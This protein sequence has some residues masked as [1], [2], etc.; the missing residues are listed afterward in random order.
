MTAPLAVLIIEDSESDTQMIVRLLKRAGYNVSFEQVENAAQMLAALQKQAW[1]IVISDYQLPQFDGLT[2]LELLKGTNLDIPFIVVS[3]LIGEESAVA[4]MKAGAHDYLAKNDLTRLAPAVARELE[5]AQGRL[6]RK[7][8]EQALHFTEQKYRNLVE[9]IPLMI[10]LD[11]ADESGSNLYISP[12]VK[13]LLGYMPEEFLENPTFWHQVIFPDDYEI[14]IGSISES[15][16]KGRAMVE[17]RM[18]TQDG[19][20]IW[21]RDTS[22]L[23]QGEEG[24]QSFI[25]GFIEDI[26]ERKQAVDALRESE[27]FTQAILKNSPIGISVRSSTGQ[28][29]SANDA[30]K[31]IWAIP[32]TDLQKDITRPRDTLN[33]NNR[34]D[35]LKLRHEDVRRVYEQGGNLY[36]PE[37]KIS[38]GRPGAAKW[39]SQHFYAIQDAQGRVSRVVI[40]T[41]DI[42]ERK[43]AHEIMRESEERL[44][45]VMEGSQLGY[46]DWN[47]QTDEV[48]RNERWA[49]MLGYTLHEIETTFNQWEELIHPDDRAHALQAV[50]DHLEGKTQIHRDEYRLRA[51]DGSYRWILD[52]GRIIEYDPQGRPLRMTATHTD[53][54]ERKQA[55]AQLR[56]LSRA[57]EQSPASIIITDVNGKI[58]YVN[59]KF[60]TL[61][62]YTLD[63]VQG[64][65]PRLLKSEKSPPEIYAELWQTILAGKEWRGEFLNRKKNG[66]LYWEYASISAITDTNGKINHFVSVNEDITIRKKTEESL[67]LLNIELEQQALTDYLTNLYNRRYFMTRGEEEFKRTKRNGQPLALLVLDID[68]FKRVNDSYGHE[69]GDRALQE[70]AKALK[71]NLREIDVLGRMGGEEFAVLLPNTSLN[72]AALLAERVRQTMENTS[73]EIPGNA[74]KIT[75]CVGV[76]A[77]VEGMSNIDDMFRNADSAMYQAKN[78]G[79]NRTVKYAETQ[80]E[81]IN[82][83]SNLDGE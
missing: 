62:G 30:W 66:E 73:F 4:M 70:V 79:R 29:L 37:L 82:L 20:I 2:A 8:A 63:E 74:L 15:L 42:T 53:I 71:S 57:V 25:Q 12:H 17:Y 43:L 36:L 9:Q 13:G 3:G 26:T 72:D 46:S 14:A 55:E 80:S 52:Q 39:V 65:T 64:K 24:K 41:E 5:Q 54:T 19:R 45:A 81:I 16:S 47:I 31:Q 48:R 76:S 58:E 61:T 67:R 44:T 22:I 78:A 51:K 60:T 21:V 7:Q 40:L 68:N 32:E 35:Y 28:L 1:D 10:Y 69:A 38:H 77:F 59:P 50:Q 23:I 18:I 11:N 27:S 75:I 34:D 6:E 49:G 83:L 56:Q 33:F